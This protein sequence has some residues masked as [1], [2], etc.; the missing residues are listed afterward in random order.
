[1]Q[2]NSAGSNPRL[3]P[4]NIGEIYKKIYNIPMLFLSNSS[5]QKTIA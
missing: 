4:E 2:G 1:M 5:R 3:C